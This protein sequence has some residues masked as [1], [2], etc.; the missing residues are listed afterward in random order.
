MPKSYI[1]IFLTFPR[2]RDKQQGDNMEEEDKISIYS[3]ARGLYT[4]VKH[5]KAWQI[6]FPFDA[7]LEEN[8]EIIEETLGILKEALEKINKEKVV[9]E[10]VKKEGS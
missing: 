1:S 5:K 9:S 8:I 6:T 4:I 3:E 2:V 10:E 7:K